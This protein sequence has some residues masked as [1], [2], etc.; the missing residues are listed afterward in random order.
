MKL[1]Y[2][3]LSFCSPLIYYLVGFFNKKV[4]RINQGRKSSLLLYK[5]F[6]Q[7]LAPEKDF[8]WFHA[9]SLGEYLQALPVI[10]NLKENDCQLKC[11]ASFFSPSGFEQAND[12]IIDLKFYLP[13]DRYK[14]FRQFF[15]FRK[16]LAIIFIKYDL[17]P[18]MINSGADAQIP[19]FLISAESAPLKKYVLHP[20]SFF[21]RL[22]RQM[23]GI[24]TNTI[25]TA[26]WLQHNGYQQAIYTGSAKIEQAA[27]LPALEYKNQNL[28]D[29]IAGRQVLMGGSIWQN[30]LRLIEMLQTPDD[31]CLI[32]APHE[33]NESKI[34]EIENAFPQ[35][36]IRL[37]EFHPGIYKVLIIDSIG[38]LSRI[39]RYADIAL[40]GGGFGKGIHN[41][42]EP[43]AYG[44]PVISGPANNSFSEATQLQLLGSYFTVNN[45]QEFNELIEKLLYDPQLRSL[46]KN[47][48]ASFFKENTGAAAK[49]S[50]LIK[51]KSDGKLAG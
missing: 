7:K 12:P 13:A 20:G 48:L 18:M 33:V 6:V 47:K 44:I 3:L 43:S 11:I 45:A 39:Y 23:T 22:L 37:S 36:T 2:K 41:I 19:M 5:E 26:A 27:S 51:D 8:Y 34:A 28:I 17:W 40:V 14:I 16:P 30:D 38:L 25:E 50:A 31:L 24:A 15:A 35:Q 32:L 1:L 21:A 49:I 42:L 10:K 29:F 9:A 4:K 46:I